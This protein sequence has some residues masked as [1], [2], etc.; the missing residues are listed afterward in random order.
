MVGW[1]NGRFRGVPGVPV[2][3]GDINRGGVNGAEVVGRGSDGVFERTD[4]A[5]V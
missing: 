1:R 2:G 4:S 3:V 5:V